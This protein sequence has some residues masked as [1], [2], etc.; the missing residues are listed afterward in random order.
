MKISVLGCGRWGT[1]IAWYLAGLKKDVLL[2][3][4][5]TSENY[6]RL[7]ETR[8]NEYV[9]LPENVALTSSLSGAPAKD[10]AALPPRSPNAT[11]RTK[12]SFCA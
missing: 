10:C 6:L 11:L 7:K 9:K 2:Y 4:R 1:F 5:E 8:S 3:G 12:S